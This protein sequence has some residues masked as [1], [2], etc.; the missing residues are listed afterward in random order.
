M[1]SAFLPPLLSEPLDHCEDCG[2]ALYTGDMVFSYDDGPTFCWQHAPTWNDLKRE[3]DELIAT[4]V[5]EGLHDTP[6]DA[7]GARQNVLDRIANGEGDKHVASP[8]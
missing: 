6:E 5:W 1:S 7:E 3:Q 4:G 2:R 8:L